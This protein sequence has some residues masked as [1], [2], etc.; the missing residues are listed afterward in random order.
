MDYYE[1]L[2]S[3]KQLAFVD[4]SYPYEVD[5]AGIYLNEQTGQFYL[6]T[7]SGCSCWDGEYDE[8][9]FDSLDQLELSLINEDSRYRPSL[10]GSKLLIAEAR[11]Y[12]EK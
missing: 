2:K 10:G 6:I 11:K 4:E 5:E 8:E 7:A 3:L 1:R 9:V 12:Y